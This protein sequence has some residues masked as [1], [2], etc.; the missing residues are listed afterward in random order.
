M[1]TQSARNGSVTVTIET[2]TS[3]NQPDTKPSCKTG[4]AKLS[5]Q[6]VLRC[7]RQF[8]YA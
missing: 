5:A 6:L 7:R 2:S 3:T 8:R 1:A 4:S